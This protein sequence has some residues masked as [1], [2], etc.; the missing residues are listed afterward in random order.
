MATSG[1]DATLT[2]YLLCEDGVLLYKNLLAST[3]VDA[4]WESFERVA[5]ALALQAVDWQIGV[6]R[7]SC[8]DTFHSCH[9]VLA[10][11]AEVVETEVVED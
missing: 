1:E 9:I 6:G 10:V 11:V 5:H 8:L 7:V 4:A 2:I 3:D